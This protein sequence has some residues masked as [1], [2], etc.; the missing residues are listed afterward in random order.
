MMVLYNQR[1]SW[2]KQ[3]RPSGKRGVML[4]DSA[5]SRAEGDWLSLLAIFGTARQGGALPW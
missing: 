3:K 5:R 4:N 1:E 2:Q